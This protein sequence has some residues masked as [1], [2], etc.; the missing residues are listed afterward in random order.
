MNLPRPVFATISILILLLLSTSVAASTPLLDYNYIFVQVSNDAGAK[1]NPFG[2]NTYNIRFEGPN[3][4]LNALH[5]STDPAANYGQVTVTDAQSGTFYATD[6]G[7]KGYDDEILLMVA[8]NGTI[9]D[10]FSL[11][12]TSDGYTW[13]P[14]PDRNQP[15]A[16][17]NVTYQ[18]V[19]LDETF[20][21]GDFLYGPQIWKPTGNGFTYPI[22][23]GQNMTDTGH[24]FLLAFIDLNAGVL[25]PN[26]ALENRG[27]VRINYS[28]HNLAS[29]AVFNVYAY[30]KNSNN[31]DDM[32][33]WTNAVPG[34]GYAVDRTGYP[35]VTGINPDTGPNTTSVSITDLAGVNFNTTSPPW[36][37]LNGTGFVDIMA[38]GVSTVS[39]SR[40][41]CTFDLTGQ[42]AGARNV[43]VTNP[44]GETG[45][46]ANG[47]TIT[48][49]G[50]APSVFS[51]TP[52]TGQNT[53]V[54]QVTNLSG[55]NFPLLCP[56]GEGPAVNLTGGG[57]ANITATDVQVLSTTRIAC[58]FDL[59]GQ[60]AGM[61]DV[62]VTS[63]DGQSGALRN[64]FTIM[65][66]SIARHHA[67]TV[68]PTGRYSGPV[69]GSSITIWTGL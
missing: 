45:I 48:E 57:F 35:V 58:T 38:S 8:V 34:S 23:S 26:A 55:A 49:P 6:S 27:A 22:Y 51:I 36:V 32:V 30:C 67:T 18:A 46:F 53:G 40:I 2:N 11:R 56:F 44:G 68:P 10:D 4:G 17:D 65:V 61:R 60:P 15:P 12:I 28:F 42:P 21:I 20:T 1:Y 59:T 69:S 13:T 54:L 64:G 47:F 24:T 29:L 37:K 41:T 19:A 14:N 52:D 31:G 5:I 63:P 39:S 43:V 66:P 3:R 33:A 9:A 50:P 7:G 16:I 25:R 62:V